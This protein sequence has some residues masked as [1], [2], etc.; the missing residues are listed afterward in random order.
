MTA[1][2]IQFRS[3]L[4]KKSGAEIATIYTRVVQ[5][6]YVFLKGGNLPVSVTTAQLYTSKTTEKARELSESHEV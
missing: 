2:F 1:E 6:F 3:P 4:S 5:V